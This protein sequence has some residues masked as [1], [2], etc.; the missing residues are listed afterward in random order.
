M[1]LGGELELFSAEDLC[2]VLERQETQLAVT[3]DVPKVGV[4]G[5]LDDTGGNSDG[6]KGT[7][8][9]IAAVRGTLEWSYR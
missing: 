5:C 4:N 7:V 6:V 1:D 3:H 8:G 9:E 2:D